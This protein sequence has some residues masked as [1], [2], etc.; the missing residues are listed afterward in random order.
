MAVDDAVVGDV[1]GQQR[2]LRVLQKLTLED[3]LDLMLLARE[4]LTG[5][6]QEKGE[7]T[8]RRSGSKSKL[9]KASQSVVGTLWN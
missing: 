8:R 7:T 9:T 1:E 6:G 4:V 2:S 5:R 3:Q